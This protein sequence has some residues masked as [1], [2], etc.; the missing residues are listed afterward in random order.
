MS[1]LQAPDALCPA[2]RP[3]RHNRTRAAILA[4]LAALILSGCGDDSSG[5]DGEGGSTDREVSEAGAG[6]PDQVD[7][8][9]LT[10]EQLCER[11]QQ[12]FIR[13]F[14]VEPLLDPVAGDESSADT[15]DARSPADDE[16]FV[17]L[18]A[19][20]Q[21]GERW[22][23]SG[24]EFAESWA[25][26]PPIC[27][28]EPY[29]A[30]WEGYEI[31]GVYCDAPSSTEPTATS[32]FYAFD[33]D[34]TIDFQLNTNAGGHDFDEALAVLQDIL[35][36]DPLEADA[37]GTPATPA[38]SEPA[39][40]DATGFSAV[41]VAPQTSGA[42]LDELGIAGDRTRGLTTTDWNV[43]TG[44]DLCPPLDAALESALGPS[45]ISPATGAG[46]AVECTVSGDSGGAL[47]V[48]KPDT[49]EVSRW[50]H[51]DLIASAL[52]EDEC[53]TSSETYTATWGSYAILGVQCVEGGIDNSVFAVL[54]D[55]SALEVTVSSID[56]HE[57]TDG[58][59]L[60][61][62]FLES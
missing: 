21:E 52:F 9:G 2:A 34:T 44:S 53:L 38:E 14:E 46:E 49:D 16:V 15:C 1:N 19:F 43:M 51:E 60:L 40:A 6:D 48:V 27:T 37:D 8:V 42:T 11:L 18:A 45:T 32:A 4:A 41:E 7:W 61:L 35:A 50:T 47:V 13:H 5:S 39:D 33:G 22:F 17:R 57:L 26:D 31:L 12:P 28:P 24:E 36:S 54:G 30:T 56:G 55:G 62:A 29:E 3:L 25:T 20:E 23:A 58:A 59:E 10:P